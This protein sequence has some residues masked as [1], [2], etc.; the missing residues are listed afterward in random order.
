LN[1]ASKRVNVIFIGKKAIVFDDLKVFADSIDEQVSKS[2]IWLEN[3]SNDELKLYYK[4]CEL[5]VF[6]SFAEGFGIP[7]LEAMVYKKKMLCAN[8]TAMADFG[9]PDEVTFDPH[10]VNEIKTK[11]EQQ[12]Q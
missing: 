6:P 4:Y 12:L 10:D 2:I 7:P 11:I 5:F 3:I 1:L 9:L 8:S